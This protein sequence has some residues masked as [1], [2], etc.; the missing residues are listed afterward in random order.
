MRIHMYMYSQQIYSHV[1]MH[2]FSTH[3]IPCG[4]PCAENACGL[5]TMYSHVLTHVSSTPT[6]GIDDQ[7]EYEGIRTLQHTATHCYTLQHTATHCNTLLHTATHCYT[8][9]HTALSRWSIRIQGN[10]NKRIDWSAYKGSRNVIEKVRCV[11]VCC[12]V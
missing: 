7:L 9:Q 5:N 1:L 12:S 4:I 2:V 3:G 6:H 11:A 8:L 10:Q